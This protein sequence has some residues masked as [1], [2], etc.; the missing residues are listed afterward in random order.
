MMHCFIFRDSRFC[1][2][3]KPMDSL[4]TLRRKKM[5]AGSNFSSK[6]IIVTCVSGKVLYQLENKGV[7]QTKKN[8]VG[9]AK[10]LVKVNG[11]QMTGF[12]QMSCRSRI[13]LLEM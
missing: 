9:M 12:S 6:D 3:N 10:N 4:L 1:T 8:R 11:G 2:S 13:G 5:R 7:F